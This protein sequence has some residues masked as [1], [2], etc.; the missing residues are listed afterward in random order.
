MGK[1]GIATSTTALTGLFSAEH[2]LTT[3]NRQRVTSA[4]LKQFCTMKAN[5]STVLNKGFNFK[6]I[7]KSWHQYKFY[8][9]INI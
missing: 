8:L 7:S 4:L 5:K 9:H 6:L 1:K 3:A 2:H